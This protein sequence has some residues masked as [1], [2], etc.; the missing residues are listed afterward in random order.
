MPTAATML[1]AHQKAIAFQKGAGQMGLAAQAEHGPAVRA[2][3]EIVNTDND[4]R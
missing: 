4:P 1:E 2:L 3:L